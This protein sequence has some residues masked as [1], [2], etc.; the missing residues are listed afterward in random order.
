MADFL[1]GGAPDGSGATRGGTGRA[2]A[3]P[4]ARAPNHLRRAGLAAAALLAAL[5]AALGAA[6]VRRTGRVVVA[7]DSMR[8]T[9]EP[10][11]RVIVLRGG[12][13]RPG[14]VVVVPDPRHARRMMIKRVAAVDGPRC[15]VVGDNR[16]STTDSRH[17]GPIRLADIQAR[18]V[19]RYFPIDRRGVL[20]HGP[21]ETAA[22]AQRC[23]NTWK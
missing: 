12:R 18:V 22:D 2:G 13:A 8:P 23:V 21:S 15:V 17:F 4:A 10:G 16:S 20:R 3:Y 19:Y 11:D 9:L 14:D 6:V 5:L 7:G 1:L